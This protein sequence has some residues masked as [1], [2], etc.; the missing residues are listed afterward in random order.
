MSLD[1]ALHYGLLKEL[2]LYEPEGKPPVDQWQ[3]SR[4]TDIDMNIDSEGQWFFEGSPIMRPRLIR[5]FASVLRR[6]NDEY[7]LVT[8]VEA[9]R[10]HVADVP[11]T[12]VLA[13]VGS[14][15]AGDGYQSVTVTT[16]VGDTFTID[17]QHPLRVGQTGPSKGLLYTHVR[18]GLE[19]KLNRSSYYDVMNRVELD[20]ETGRYVIRSAGKAFEVEAS[21]V[22]SAVSDA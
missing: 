1:H 7:F 2:G 9:C 19:A 10:I 17:Q 20:E 11:F 15:G 16:N 6:D 22:S 5:L 3:P 4:V 8:P 14:D 18:S 13:D 21:G 12:V